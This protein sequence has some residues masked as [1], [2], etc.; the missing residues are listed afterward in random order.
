MEPPK[1]LQ[2]I[3]NR[4]AAEGDEAV[5]ICPALLQRYAS[6]RMLAIARMGMLDKAFSYLIVT[7][8]NVHFVRPGML[9]D[10]VETVPLEKISGVEYAQEFLHNTLQLRVGDATENIVFYDEPDGINFYR[11]VK[12]K[13]WKS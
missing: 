8:K 4:L 2:R 9:W 3:L 7:K 13:Q 10:K 6:E 1:R 12:F 5:I 11:Y